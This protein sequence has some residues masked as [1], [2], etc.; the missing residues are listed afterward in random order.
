MPIVFGIG[1]LNLNGGQYVNR[2]FHELFLSPLAW[3]GRY[4]KIFSFDAETNGLWGKAFAIGAVVKDTETGTE[5]Q[6]VGRC[7]IEGEVNPFVEEMVLP[8]MVDIPTTHHNYED[9]LEGFMKFYMDNKEDAVCLVHIGLPVEA[10]L[11]ID[12]HDKGIIGDWDAPF[13]LVDCSAIPSIGTSVDIYNQEH[14]LSVPSF[15][16][17]THNPLYDSYAALVAY[18]HAIK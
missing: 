3:S 6:W 15:K 11:F 18:S 1:L 12:A 7:P 2:D 9:L 8:Q 17:G 13:P 4:M 14:G 10:R 16:G 5:K